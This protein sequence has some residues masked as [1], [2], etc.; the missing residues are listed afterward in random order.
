MVRIT[1]FFGK[2]SQPGNQKKQL[3]NPTKG[4][5]RFKKNYWPCLDKKT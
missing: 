3:A 2:C 1:V 5:L 4:F